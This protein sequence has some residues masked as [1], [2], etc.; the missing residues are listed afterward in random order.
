MTE[1]GDYD[2]GVWKGHDFK[3]ARKQYDVHVGRSYDDARASGKSYRKLIESCLSTESESPIVIACDVTG[4]MGEWP[5]TMFSKMPYLDKEGQ[6]YFGKQMEISFAAIGD[7]YSDKYPLQVR[8]FA[9]DLDLKKRLE[10]LVIEKNGGGQTMESYDLCALY[11]ARKVE[12]PKAANPLFIF[13]G[14]EGLYDFGDIDSAKKYADIDITKR[15]PTKDVIDELKRKYS[16][17]LIRKPYGDSADG[18]TDTMDDTNKR[19]YK[20]WESLLGADHIAPLPVA[21][22][23]VDVIFGIMAKEKDRIEYFEKELKGRQ[24]PDQVKT[25]MKSLEPIHE[26]ARQIAELH[27]GLSV[28]RKKGSGSNAKPLL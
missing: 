4:S 26:V 18:S 16:V 24:R 20:Q 19:I 1:S 25:V 11:Y 12:M 9:K 5:A 28:K 8:P 6:E 7:V 17:Y 3:A 23:V 22:R 21:D 14:D 10:E 27:P 2:P 13:I 15:M